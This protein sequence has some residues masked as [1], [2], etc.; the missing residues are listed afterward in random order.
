MHCNYYCYVTEFLHHFVCMPI[1][2]PTHNPGNYPYTLCYYA[3]FVLLGLFI[4]LTV[5]CVS[6]NVFFLKAKFQPTVNLSIYS[7]SSLVDGDLG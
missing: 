5:E 2:T 4:S 3:V 6:Q 1:V 7:V